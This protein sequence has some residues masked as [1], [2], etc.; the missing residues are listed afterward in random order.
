M[1]QCNRV[2]DIINKDTENE[3]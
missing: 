1:P 3:Q 2:R